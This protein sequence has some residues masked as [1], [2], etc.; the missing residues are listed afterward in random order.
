MTDDAQVTEAMNGADKLAKAVDS[1]AK[2][3]EI[4]SGHKARLMAAGISKE[5]ADTMAVQLHATL[6]AALAGAA[7][8]RKPAPMNREKLRA[9]RRGM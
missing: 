6:L 1:I 7:V 8:N 2:L 9:K 5:A 4:V 3:S